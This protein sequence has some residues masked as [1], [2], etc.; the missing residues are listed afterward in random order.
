DEQRELLSAL[1]G[2]YA[3]G[4]EV[5]WA[6]FFAGSGARRVDL[7]TY[8]FQHRHYWLEAQSSTGDASEFGQLAAEHPL[9]GAVV[10]LPSTDGVVLTGRLSLRSHPWLADHGV[11]G[12]VLLPGTAFVELAIKAGDQVGCDLLE[13]LTL[14]AP[15]VVPE[16]G[17]VALRVVAGAPDGSGACTVTVHSRPDDT[18]DG[19]WTRHAEGVLRPAAGRLPEMS[20]ELTEWPPRGAQPVEV[21]GAYELLTGRGYGYGP[22][23]QGLKAAWRRGDEVFAEVALPDQAKADAAL[24]GLHPALLD[25]AMHAD[26]LDEQGETLLPFVWSGVRL[27]A[28][29]ASALR[30]RIRRMNGDELSSI[31]VAD[32][33]GAP[34]ASVET[35]VSRPVSA[36]QLEAAGTGHHESLLTVEWVAPPPHVAVAPPSWAELAAL[37]RP[38]ADLAALAAGTA[39]PDVVFFS[40]LGEP[41]EDVP[42]AV[43][44]VTGRVLAV[45]QEW[46]AGERFAASKLV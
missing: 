39:V 7:P 18:P 44:S 45:V 25:A 41:G 28:V 12:R 15:L 40:G 38:G 42:A 16:R 17:G 10:T 3:S 36:K 13:E 35:L 22:V 11:L 26:L 23:F 19:E 21:D 1:G 8:A 37:G 31:V 20:A 27:H 14:E 43:R 32:A 30:V 24:F 6:A 4:A 33:T 29:G 9:L 34:V 46:L 5:D 2:V